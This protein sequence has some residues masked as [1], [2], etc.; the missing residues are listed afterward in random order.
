MS[1]MEH[2]KGKLIP[3]NLDLESYDEDALDELLHDNN[4]CLIDG[5]VYSV[6]W[7]VRRGELYDFAQVKQN[8]DGSIDFNTYHYNGGGHWTEVIENALENGS[9][10]DD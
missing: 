1:D 3:V 5:E 6:Q 4:W 10:W 2:N 8:D 9:T 7:E